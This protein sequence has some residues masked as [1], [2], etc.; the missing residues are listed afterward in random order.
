MGAAV[1]VLAVKAR[2]PA[3]WFNVCSFPALISLARE[4]VE[5]GMA[6]WLAV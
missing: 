5:R 2:T 4:T 1:T 3:I 6:A